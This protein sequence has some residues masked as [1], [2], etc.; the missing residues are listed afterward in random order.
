MTSSALLP[1]VTAMVAGTGY[2]QG[3]ANV[4]RAAAEAAAGEPPVDWSAFAIGSGVKG[5][6]HELKDYGTICDLDLDP[7][8]VGL[9]AP[10]QV[11]LCPGG[12]HPLHRDFC[13]KSNPSDVNMLL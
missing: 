8:L 11:R 7:N 3:G 4:C 5:T 2:V 10:H 6:V 9:V 1:V 13:Q 12:L